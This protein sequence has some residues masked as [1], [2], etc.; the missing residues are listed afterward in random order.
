MDDTQYLLDELKNPDWWVRRNAIKG[1]LTRPEDAYLPFLESALRNHE[2]ATLRNASM[3]FFK[4]MGSRA[5]PSLIRLIGDDAD[6]EARLFA[7]NL[8]GD[9][10]DGT[11]L[12][13]LMP[14]L[15]DPDTNVRIASAE[16]LGKIGLPSAIAALSG[17]LEDE[18]WVAQ[19]AINSIGEIGGE[20][21]LEVLY[22]CVEKDTY[23]GM[24]FEAIERA[25]NSKSIRCL[26]AFVDKDDMR[27]LALKAVVNISEREKTRPAPGYFTAM[28]PM[29]IELQ[30]SPRP[31]IGRAAL[32]ALSWSA[33]AKGIPY[34]VDALSNDELQEYAIGGLMDIGRKAA[35]AII[36]ALKDTGRLQRC[37][38]A[39]ML[40]M[41]G[42]QAA[43]VQFAEDND[44]EVKVEAV[45]ALGRIPTQRSVL[46]LS[47][48]LSD[49]EEEIRSAAKRAIE[50]LK[51][52]M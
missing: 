30:G 51:R 41:L 35:P 24:A 38:L 49:P 2:D 1:L 6:E 43:L 15:K 12:S 16:A 44:P 45:L 21:A 34:L 36:D 13:V 5:L 17:A 52:I 39:K 4:A 42:E 9:I 37:V 48:M 40:S 29:L 46:L 18:P 28:V 10:R 27:E 32:I 11:A 47:K 50:D 31:D 19:A 26:T 20:S 25:G 23:R 33:D 8:L 3:E 22:R 7:A 14:A